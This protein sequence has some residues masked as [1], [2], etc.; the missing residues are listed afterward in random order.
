MPWQAKIGR[1]A[2]GH[3]PYADAAIP[4]PPG[5]WCCRYHGS[6]SIK[7]REPTRALRDHDVRVDTNDRRPTTRCRCM[8]RWCA[9]AVM[10]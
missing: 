4:Q 3:G 2:E 6:P 1:K 5:E 7:L 10:Q 8:W 9:E